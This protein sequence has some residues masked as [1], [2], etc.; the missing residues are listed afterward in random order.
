MAAVLDAVRT[1]LGVTPPHLSEGEMM[2]VTGTIERVEPIVGASYHTVA[3]GVVVR[4][5]NVEFV[6]HHP[7][8][9]PHRI[10]PRWWGA[11]CPVG[12]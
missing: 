2:E 11:G 5:V 6:P 8:R 3:G 9:R 7:S 10:L 4:F 12:A 1:S